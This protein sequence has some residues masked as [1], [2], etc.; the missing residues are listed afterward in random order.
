MENFPELANQAKKTNV[1]IVV[2]IFSRRSHETDAR[3]CIKMWVVNRE[4]SYSCW[5][6]YPDHL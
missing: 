2:D 4:E 3:D 6:M 5:L 1:K